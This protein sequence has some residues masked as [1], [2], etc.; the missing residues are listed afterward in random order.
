VCRSQQTNRRHHAHTWHKLT[1]ETVA[2]TA[3]T[4]KTR[5]TSSRRLTTCDSFQFPLSFSLTRTSL[6][7]LDARTGRYVP[8]AGSVTALDVEPIGRPTRCH[9][10]DQL[11]K[12]CLC[13]INTPTCVSCTSSSNLPFKSYFLS[14]SCASKNADCN[15]NGTCK[16][17]E[18]SHV[19]LSSQSVNLFLRCLNQSAIH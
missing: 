4:Y 3:H 9:A 10:N 13:V 15:G 14:V 11:L 17:R 1:R 16:S 6:I 18:R 12:S 8:R 19:T 7:V 2:L 5:T